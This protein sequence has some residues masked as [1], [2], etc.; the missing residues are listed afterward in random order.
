[1]LI[2]TYKKIE[3]IVL[4]FVIK[5]NLQISFQIVP[6]HKTTSLTFPSF[7]LLIEDARKFQTKI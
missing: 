6:E 7:K 4:Y 1:M 5:K 3:T 2:K